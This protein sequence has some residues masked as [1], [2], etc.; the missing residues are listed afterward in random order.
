VVVWGCGSGSGAECSVPCGLANVTAIATG[1]GHNLALI[2]PTP[3][4]ALLSAQVKGK[5]VLVKVQLSSWKLYPTLVG[6]K[7]NKLD[8][9]HWRIVIDGKPNTISTKPTAGMTTKLTP[10]R[11]RVW[12]KLVNNDASD[13]AATHASRSVTVVIKR[14][15]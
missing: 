13:V 10:G 6:K 9:G 11:H 5:V 2:G 7:P 4:I 15:R 1:P 3:S 14:S 12:V 8:G